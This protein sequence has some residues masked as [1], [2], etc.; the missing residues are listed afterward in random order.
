[1]LQ[2]SATSAT[3]FFDGT[4]DSDVPAQAAG[5]M[6]GDALILRQKY[7][8]ALPGPKNSRRL[9][10]SGYELSD[11]N[12]GNN[13]VVAVAKDPAPGT[14][15]AFP[16]PNGMGGSRDWLLESEN[17]NLLPLAIAGEDI[18]QKADQG[19]YFEKANQ[20]IKATRTRPASSSEL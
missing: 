7:D 3:K 4:V 10:V 8:N 19:S 16:N 5:L 11:G 17:L 2:I 15:K 13:Y 6:P 9:S 14:I 1:M 12:G 18:L 20:A